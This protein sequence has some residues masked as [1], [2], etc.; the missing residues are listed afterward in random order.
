MAAVATPSARDR[1]ARESLHEWSAAWHM[2]PS[3]WC[4]DEEAGVA[5]LAPESDI[6]AGDGVRAMLAVRGAVV[7]GGRP[8]PP[9][10]WPGLDPAEGAATILHDVL[11]RD[12]DALASMR[13]QFAL[14]AWDGRRGRLLAARDHFGQRGLFTRMEDGVLLICSELAPLLRMGGRCEL[15]REAA[16]WYLAFGLPPPGR[17][18]ARGIGRVP[19]AHALIWEPGGP[20]RVARYWTPLDPDAPLDAD[21]AV[22]D[23]LRSAVDRATARYVLDDAGL[24]VLLSGGIDST[25][26]SATSVGLGRGDMVALTAAFEPEHGMNESAFAVAV[27]DWLGIRHEVVDLRGPAA[28]ELIEDVLLGAAEPCSA[29]AV[30][31]HLR[32]LARAHQLGLD[33]VVSGLGAD[34]LF[35]GYD[36][37]RGYYARFLRDRARRAVP[38]APDHFESLL[39]DESR[40]ATRVLYPGV[41]R[42][43]D[44]GAL[45][46]ALAPPYR[47]WHYGS[48]L[49]DIN[50]ECRRLKPGAHYMEMAVAH[51]LQ[52][53][54][55]DLLHAGFEP[56]SRRIGVEVAYPFLDPD[57]ARL[58]TGLRAES[59]YR[60]RTGH[61]SLRLRDIHPRFK[62][63]MLM[64]AADR[65]PEPIRER[66]RKSLTAPFGAWMFDR[67]FAGALLPRLRESGFWDERIVRREYLDSILARLEPRPTPPAFQLWALVTLAGWY[68]RFAAPR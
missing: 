66:P 25:Y 53:R 21:E 35:G 14:V 4:V 38:G 16:F 64:M 55:P 7:R 29:W 20:A 46:A 5:L 34:E 51:E 43:F 45:R 40:A 2:D 31:T 47:H 61:F 42:F 15:D 60:T 18:L 63:A 48:H 36:H 54:V 59:R 37:A 8:D 41:S 32:T 19:A 11:E 57:V 65:V 67:R 27:A 26:L 44:D 13:G 1:L 30:V 12:T 23:R 9:R 49:R 33:R 50:R 22:V 62:H 58:A 56:V 10:G 28:A 17:T 6:E 39:A 68:D 3:R 24:G 52:H